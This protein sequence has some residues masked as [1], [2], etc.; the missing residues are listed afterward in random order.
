MTTRNLLWGLAAMVALFVIGSIIGGVWDDSD[1]AGVITVT[2]WAVSIIGAAV[3]L[4]LLVVA[5]FRRRG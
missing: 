2:L 1:V 4:L 3:L 5:A